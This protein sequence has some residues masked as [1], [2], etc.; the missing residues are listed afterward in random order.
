[1]DVLHVKPQRLG[2]FRHKLSCAGMIVVI[3]HDHPHRDAIRQDHRRDR[4]QR[5]RD[6]RTAE[7]ADADIDLGHRR[8]IL[9]QNPIDHARCMIIA[10]GPASA[11]TGS[12]SFTASSS[13]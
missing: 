12:F 9:R 13:P 6:M 5:V 8:I 11:I 2:R 3:G 1:M 4:S 7:G 10:A